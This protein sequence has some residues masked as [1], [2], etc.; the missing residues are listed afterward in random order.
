M[1][2]KNSDPNLVLCTCLILSSLS[3]SLAKSNVD[4]QKTVEDKTAVDNM[5]LPNDPNQASGKSTNFLSISRV[6]P[7][8]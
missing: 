3:N 2:L 6:S 5:N 8:Y 4:V 1:F 7:F